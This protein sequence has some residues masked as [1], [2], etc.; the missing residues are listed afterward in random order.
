ME[1]Q[2]KKE[3]GFLK[4][5]EADKNSVPSNPNIESHKKKE[6]EGYQIAPEDTMIGYDGND[7]Q[8]NMDTGNINLKIKGNQS[9]DDNS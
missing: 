8:M 6:E 2:Q 9:I 1:N 5:T 4:P 3:N 7:D